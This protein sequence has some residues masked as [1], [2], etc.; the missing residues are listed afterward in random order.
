MDAREVWVDCVVQALDGRAPAAQHLAE[1]A[2]ARAVHGVVHDLQP[3]G[4]Q[5]LQVHQTTH[6]G[7][8]GGASVDRLQ[9]VALLRL[10]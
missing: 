10:G 7:Q 2:H 4:P 3:A 1:E 5:P 8:V 6:L 9:T